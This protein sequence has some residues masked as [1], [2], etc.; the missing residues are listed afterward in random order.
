MLQRAFQWLLLLSLLLNGLG[1]AAA[2]SMRMAGMHDMH[3]R[4]HMGVAVQMAPDPGVSDHVDPGH[5]TDLAMAGD[6]TKCSNDC[7]DASGACQCPCL[8]HLHAVA[9]GAQ[10]LNAQDG[11]GDVPKTGTRGHDAPPPAQSTRPPIA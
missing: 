4:L 2:S 10:T 11:H 1:G 3:G 5:A 6:D 7:C 8:H 9:G